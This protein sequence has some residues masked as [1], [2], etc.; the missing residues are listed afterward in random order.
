MAVFTGHPEY[1]KAMLFSRL[2]GSQL[3][4]IQFAFLTKI[5]KAVEEF[6]PDVI[7]VHH[8]SNLSWIANYIKAVYQIH[9][10]ITSHNTD[11]INAV[12]DKRYIPLT[13]D[14]INRADFIT[15]VSF[16]TKERFI[17]ILGKGSPKLRNK[18][19]VVPC[20]VDIETFPPTG[21]FSSIAKKYNP[22]NSKI[23]LYCGKI[24]SF[25][26]VDIFVRSAHHFPELQYIIVGDGGEIANIKKIVKD[27]KISN[28]KF[29][30]YLGSKSKNVLSQ[31]YRMADV[32]V[33]PS[34]ISEGI[35][36]TLL[37]AMASRTAVIGSNIGGIPTAVRHL[38][39]G[40]LIKPSSIR[41]LVYAIRHL[42]SDDSFREKCATQA[43]IDAQRKFDWNVLVKQF[44]KYYAITLKRSIKN[45]RSKKPSF[46]S[47]GVYLESKST[48]AK[49]EKLSSRG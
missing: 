11:I 34:T 41:S 17:K 1:P 24:T 2:T 16:N 48:A 22:L 43:H 49:K 19:R 10:I 40:L 28:V 30:G 32:V 14:A 31:F 26:G 21:S 15:A 12:L 8:A 33:S 39:N 46:V 45:K 35:P 36:L 42:I 23:M 25:K 37:E 3:N 27:E 47:Q 18:M 5:I 13:Q 9:Y 7:H 29:A 6:K 38:K 4:D 20:G 44:E